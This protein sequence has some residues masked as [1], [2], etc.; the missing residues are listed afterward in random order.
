MAIPKRVSQVLA[1]RARAEGLGRMVA[2]G[3]EMDPRLARES[4]APTPPAR[5]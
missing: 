4:L 3:D 1:E 5:P 2:G